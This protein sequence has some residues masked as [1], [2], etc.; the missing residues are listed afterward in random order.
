MFSAGGSAETGRNLKKV[1]K[2]VREVE[3][4]HAAHLRQIGAREIRR[5]REPA[6]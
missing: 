4:K 2:N 3:D 1:A 6:G 5:A